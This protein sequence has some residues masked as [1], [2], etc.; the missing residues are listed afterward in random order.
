M[1]IVWRVCLCR[2]RG[3]ES[4]RAAVLRWF[5]ERRDVSFGVCLEGCV[6]ILRGVY[7]V[8]MSLSFPSSGCPC[9]LY[10]QCPPSLSA[11]HRRF[12]CGGR[13]VWLFLLMSVVALESGGELL[14]EVNT[15]SGRFLP[16]SHPNFRDFP[17]TPVNIEPSPL[18]QG[19]Y[20][21]PPLPYFTRVGRMVQWFQPQLVDAL[22]NT[23][24]WIV[25]KSE[26][27]KFNSGLIL[28]SV[29][30]SCFPPQPCFFSHRCR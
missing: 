25:H 24:L 16:P 23:T 29:F 6:K 30:W 17:R 2:E 7:L 27:S 3:V 10:E 20:S 13:P 4:G 5:L 26:S 9:V 1:L 14:D 18:S 15:C 19:L 12:V 28:F 11:E 22:G 8:P 21:Y